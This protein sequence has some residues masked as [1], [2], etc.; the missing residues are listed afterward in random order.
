MA[1]AIVPESRKAMN[2]SLYTPRLHGRHTVMA[3]CGAGERLGPCSRSG[4][5]SSCG[6]GFCALMALPSALESQR[7][8]NKDPI[9][10]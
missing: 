10:H 7:H 8:H 9:V 6:R 5:F 4:G 1:V 2:V 3:G